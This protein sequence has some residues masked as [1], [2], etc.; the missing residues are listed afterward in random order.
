MKKVLITGV[1]GDVG[2]A[3]AEKFSE[4]GYYVIGQYNKSAPGKTDESYRVDLSDK[5]QTREFCEIINKKHPDVDVLINNAG[6]DWY[7]VFTDMNDGEMEKIMTVDLY[8]PMTLTREIGKNML[9]NKK[10]VVLNVTSIWGRDGGSCEV[11]YSA[12][13]GG[14]ISFTKAIAKEWGLS[15]VRSNAL[16]LGFLD[17]KMNERFTEEDRKNFCEGVALGR[18]GTTKEA[19]DT[20]YFL[21]SEQ[22]AYVTGQVVSVDGGM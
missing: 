3:L 14:L 12:A 15:G 5:N 22:A 19:A 18:I 4:N 7:G 20:A 6:I 8:A 2:K 21:C 11:A 17:T 1:S 13:K 9:R 10:G 16:C